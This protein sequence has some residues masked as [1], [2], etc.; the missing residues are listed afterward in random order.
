MIDPTP[1]TVRAYA[2][3]ML[4]VHGGTLRSKATAPEMRAIAK[5]LA[6][7]GITP[8]AAFLSSFVTTIGASI[9]VPFTLGEADPTWALWDQISVIAHECRHLAQRRRLGLRYEYDYLT[10]GA[11]RAALEAEAFS[12]DAELTHWRHGR[13]PIEWAAARAESLRS[14]GI[15]DLDIAVCARHISIVVHSANSG[16][17]LSPEARTAINWLEAHAPELAAR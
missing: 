1:E 10:S 15:R 9:Y 6:L 13:L 16:L 2:A 8:E 5:G 11:R 7:L 3:H 14:Y 12:V 4:A 17:V